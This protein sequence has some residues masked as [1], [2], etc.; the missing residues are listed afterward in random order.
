MEHD[1]NYVRLT[2]CQVLCVSG[3][4]RGGGKISK[5]GLTDTRYKH[6]VFANSS[7]PEEPALWYR[8]INGNAWG[9]VGS[10][11]ADDVDAIRSMLNGPSSF[12]IVCRVRKEPYP[13]CLPRVLPYK[14]L[15]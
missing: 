12:H 9:L 11:S 13:G 6:N 15:L 5:G 3:H 2:L 4:N 14:Q 10:R 1:N 7:T 8:E